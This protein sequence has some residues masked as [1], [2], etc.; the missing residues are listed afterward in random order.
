[1][2]ADHALVPGAAGLPLRAEVFLVTATEAATSE[3]AICAASWAFSWSL[4]FR[5]RA[6]TRLMMEAMELIVYCCVRVGT[7][8]EGHPLFQFLLKSDVWDPLWEGLL[9]Q[10]RSFRGLFVNLI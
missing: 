7:D 4:S 8:M 9:G 5:D 2:K 1:M 3:Q 10:G 6:A